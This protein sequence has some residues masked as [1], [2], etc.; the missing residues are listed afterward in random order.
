MKE[1]VIAK[2]IL[3]RQPVAK[4]DVGRSILEV[5][6]AAWMQRQLSMFPTTLYSAH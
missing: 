2:N 1:A 3:C 5:Q 4:R 6:P